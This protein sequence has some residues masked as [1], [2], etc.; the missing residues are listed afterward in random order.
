MESPKK[1]AAAKEPKP[2]TEEPTATADQTP[3]PEKPAEP[4]KPKVTIL[5]RKTV[6]LPTKLSDA[7]KIERGT[8]LARVLE[9]MSRQRR[10]IRRR[11]SAR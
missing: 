2:A 7:E 3:G 4:E 10:R 9:E 5:S 1:G 11:R 8:A 6:A